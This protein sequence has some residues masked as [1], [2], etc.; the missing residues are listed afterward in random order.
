MLNIFLYPIIVA[1]C[2]F[3]LFFFVFLYRYATF[4]KKFNEPINFNHFYIYKVFDPMAFSASFLLFS[5][6]FYIALT[7]AL[8]A[9]PDTIA[10]SSL[11]V[12]VFTVFA[13]CAVFYLFSLISEKISLLFFPRCIYILFAFGFFVFLTLIYLAVNI[14]L[15]NTIYYVI[16]SALTLI[17]G[18]I[19]YVKFA[20]KLSGTYRY[21]SRP[22]YLSKFHPHSANYTHSPFFDDEF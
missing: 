16:L 21:G 4:P 17:L 15:N 6:P 7:N 20:I 8:W 14:F 10:A 3:V 13:W 2:L 5:A 18:R 1:L 22:L 12:K 11:G 9:N 19:R